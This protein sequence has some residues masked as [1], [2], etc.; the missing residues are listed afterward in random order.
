MGETITLNSDSNH[1]NNISFLQALEA[2]TTEAFPGFGGTREHVH[3]FQG[4]RKQRQIFYGNKRTKLI[5]GNR[6]HGKYENHF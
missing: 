1:L 5:M 4:T 3:F 6:E 2:V